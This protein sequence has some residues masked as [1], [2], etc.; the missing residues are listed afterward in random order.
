MKN[1]GVPSLLLQGSE[2]LGMAYAPALWA[3]R[4]TPPLP[5]SADLEARFDDAT[6]R[7]AIAVWMH[8]FAAAHHYADLAIALGGDFRAGYDAQFT[9]LFHPMIDLY[10]AKTP[11]DVPPRPVRDDGLDDA[12]AGIWMFMTPHLATRHGDPLN[13]KLFIATNEMQA[14]MVA[15]QQGDGAALA[16]R[17][18]NDGFVKPL[19]LIAVLPL[20]KTHREELVRAL[21]WMPVSSQ[22]VDYR[23][24]FGAAQYYAER[25]TMFELAGDTANAKRTG[26]VFDRYV[27]AFHD[28]RRLVALAIFD[29]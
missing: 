29:L 11:L 21:A 14:A 3:T 16:T 1:D 27:E 26:D 13:T 2:A 10:T 22:I 6:H 19:D 9:S 4:L 20:V 23:F 17:L 28:H 8:D 18:G 25:R 24:P 5:E 7:L 15:A 12:L